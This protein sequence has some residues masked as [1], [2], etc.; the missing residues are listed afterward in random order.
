MSAGFRRAV[1]ASVLILLAGCGEQAPETTLDGIYTTAQ[2]QRGEGLY[3]QHC[4][5]CHSIQEFSGRMFDTVWTGTP[6]SALYLRIA[7]TMPMDQPGSLG[8]RQVTALMAHIFAEN[9][10]P[11]GD[12]PL[13]S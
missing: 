13:E 1:S 12:T 7:N 3:A 9:H 10:M 8:T 5:R 6:A 11:S 2:A 4:A